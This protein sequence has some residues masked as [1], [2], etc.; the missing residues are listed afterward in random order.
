VNIDARPEALTL[1]D[2][3]VVRYDHAAGGYAYSWDATGY[4]P[5]YYDIF[6]SFAD[7]S[8]QSCRIQLAEPAE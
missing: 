2:H 4:E 7:G 1:L 3:W 5:G 8:S 6:L